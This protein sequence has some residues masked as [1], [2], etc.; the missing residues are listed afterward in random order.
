MTSYGMGTGG[1]TGWHRYA[2]Y[3]EPQQGRPFGTRSLR[4]VDYIETPYYKWWKPSVEG[5]RQCLR[6][7]LRTIS[8]MGNE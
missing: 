7:L 3:T 4:V 1:F 5:E 8:S 6:W 2:Y